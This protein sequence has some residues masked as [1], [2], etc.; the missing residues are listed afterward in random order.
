MNETVVGT[1]GEAHARVGRA[2][3]PELDR[4]G[5][6]YGRPREGAGA[7]PEPPDPRQ[8]D[9]CRQFLSQCARTKTG[10]ISSY[11]LKHVIERWAAA[12]NPQDDY[13]S[14]GAAIRAALELGLVVS[15]NPRRSPNAMVGV[16]V[17]SCAALD[18]AEI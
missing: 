2:A 16:S 11:A 14:N 7:A 5:F 10:R 13:V 3:L 18:T 4:G 12:Q 15:P 17:R 6:V 1:E 8:V 9:L